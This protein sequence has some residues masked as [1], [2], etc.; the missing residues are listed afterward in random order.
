MMGQKET[1]LLSSLP[2]IG[3]HLLKW[4]NNEDNNAEGKLSMQSCFQC[5]PLMC[6]FG[7]ESTDFL[8]EQL[9]DVY[10]FVVN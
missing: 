10:K 3:L 7:K 6:I 5:I 9:R 2:L 8:Q 4:S 1:N